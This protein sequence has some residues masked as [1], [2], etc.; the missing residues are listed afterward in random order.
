MNGWSWGSWRSGSTSTWSRV[1]ARARRRVPRRTVRSTARRC[2]TTQRAYL[3]SARDDMRS[4]LRSGGGALE[5]LLKRAVVQAVQLLVGRLEP[6]AGRDDRPPREALLE[7]LEPGVQIRDVPRLVLEDRADHRLRPGIAGQ[8]VVVGAQLGRRVV[9]GDEGDGHELHHLRVPGRATVRVD[10][11]EV[12]GPAPLGE[13]L[14]AVERLGHSRQV[15]P[16]LLHP[17]QEEEG[18]PALVHRVPGEVEPHL[19]IGHQ[20]AQDE[21]LGSAAHLAG[22]EQV[23]DRRGSAHACMEA[24]QEVDELLVRHLHD[25][26]VAA[27]D[28]GRGPRYRTGPN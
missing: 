1:A 26:S 5:V 14:Q 25:Y 10:L 19:R 20:L 23:Q 9:L 2:L 11:L 24:A 18:V 22:P 8:G 17:P 21:D 4:L 7:P 13:R 3:S 15:E 12:A 27:K 16:E 28:T 6:L